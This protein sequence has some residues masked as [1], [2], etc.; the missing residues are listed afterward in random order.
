[1][2]W[3]AVAVGGVALAGTAGSLIYANNS[4]P[5]APQGNPTSAKTAELLQEQFA[6]W[7]KTFKPIELQALNQVS[8]NNS[9]VLPGAL[10]EAKAGVDS[11]YSSIPGMLERQ[12]RSLGIEPTAQQNKSTQ[13]MMNVNQG[14]ATAG[15]ENSARSN[16]RQLDEQILMGSTP[17]PNIAKAAQ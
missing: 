1:M 6:D 11:A 14:L 2:T 8:L 16:V 7:E 12:N 4:R 13:R 15:A 3:A 10:D 9:A 5:D 17:N